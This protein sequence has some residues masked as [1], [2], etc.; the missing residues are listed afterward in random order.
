MESSE[1]NPGLRLQLLACI[2]TRLPVEEFATGMTHDV[3]RAD[4]DLAIRL[5]DD[6]R[7][8]DEII[9]ALV[10]R[11]VDPGQ[12]AQLLDNLSKG[13]K[14][15]PQSPPSPEMALGRRSRTKS[16]PPGNEPTRSSHS[17][18]ATARNGSSARSAGQGRKRTAVFWLTIAI[19]V[20]L[21]IAAGTIILIQR[22]KANTNPPEE[23]EPKAAIPKAA[24]PSQKPPLSSL[25]L[26]L[27][28]D[29]LHLGGSV[30]TPD[31]VLTVVAKTLGVAT[32]TNQVGQADTVIYAYDHAGLL[33]YSQ[34][35]GGT[36]S[37]V[38]DCEANGG[39]HG[40]MSPFNGTL[41]V[42]G[43][44][45]RTD[46]DPRT[47]TAIKPLGLSRP[48]SHNGIWGGRYNGLNLVFAYLK[49][50]QRLSLIE[51]DLK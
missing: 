46:T 31:N 49:S 47:L 20:G 14:P 44:V 7:P 33:V 19:F 6:H 8:D 25:V 48:G 21:V 1:D 45:I 11:G 50:P 4:I 32:R 51:I 30:V 3:L 27:Q 18:R 10:H 40:T 28:P 35:G 9:L 2:W 23:Q 12:A 39:I 36:N 15:T 17:S 34:Q 38:L 22:H 29:G 41:T 42:E 5:R 26:E 43:Q 37:I 16:V 13:I 24:V